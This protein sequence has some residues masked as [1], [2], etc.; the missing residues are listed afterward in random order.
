MILFIFHLLILRHG[1]HR[2]RIMTAHYTATM[3][4]QYAKKQN[5][6]GDKV[7]LL[8]RVFSQRP[9]IA[10]VSAPPTLPHKGA[11]SEA[12]TSKNASMLQWGPK[13]ESVSRTNKLMD[14]G[15]NYKI[16]PTM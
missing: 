1:R 6:S 11:G 3:R 13:G 10:G 9:D 7:D 12:R 14:Y 15:K 4:M 5:E 8:Y 16:M 2:T